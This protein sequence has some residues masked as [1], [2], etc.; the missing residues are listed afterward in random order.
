M[1]DVSL[2]I[3]GGIGTKEEYYKLVKE[4]MLKSYKR[5]YIKCTRGNTI[6]ELIKDLELFL[7]NIQE[8]FILLGHSFGGYVSTGLLGG[9][10]TNS[11]LKGFIMCNS[12][13]NFSHI[14]L[15]QNYNE[16]TEGYVKEYPFMKELSKYVDKQIQGQQM[17]IAIKNPLL[18]QF[19]NIPSSI[20]TLFVGSG[21]DG[22]IPRDM[23]LTMVTLFG[24]NRPMRN[25]YWC[26]VD[27][28]KHLGLITNTKCYREIIDFNLTILLH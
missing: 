16:S 8:D 24:E 4:E 1:K 11:K 21:K 9:G 15:K 25:V 22:Y 3:V 23:I 17:M 13:Y 14:D 19:K 6:E 28:C 5:V 10:Y 2:V 20:P 27:E 7:N 26:V 12:C 18:K